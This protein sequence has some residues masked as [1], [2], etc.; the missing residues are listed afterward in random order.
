V[1]AA[2]QI[3]DAAEAPEHPDKRRQFR[4]VKLLLASEPYLHPRLFSW[5]MASSW[6]LLADRDGLLPTWY[7]AI[8]LRLD[9]RE[10]A[11]RQ[12]FLHRYDPPLVRFT[13][14]WLRSGDI[15]VDV[16]ANAGQLS[17]VGAHQVG[18]HGRVLMIEPNPALSARLERL[19]RNNPLANMKL[20][21]LAL[22]LGVLVR[23]LTLPGARARLDSMASSCITRTPI[24]WPDS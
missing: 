6:P 2:I 9:L 1:R 20:F 23:A 13:A 16:G 21:D 17:A 12:A 5:L 11:E 3:A 24:R 10:G 7:G 8:E 15:F 4:L 18:A 22:G 19:A 14:T